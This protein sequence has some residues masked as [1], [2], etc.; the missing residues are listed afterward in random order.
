MKKTWNLPA[1]AA[2]GVAILASASVSP[3]TADEASVRKEFMANHKKAVAQFKA[4][5][6]KG[7]MSMYAPDYKGKSMEGKDETRASVERDMKQAMA[8]TKLVRRADLK[9]DKLNLKGAN[10]D[11]ESTFTL[12]IRAIDSTGQ[13]G[14]KGKTH[15]MVMV[16]RSK[17]K[18][19]KGAEGWKIK[20]SEPLPGST[21]TMDGKPFPPAPS[22]K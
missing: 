8:D 3:V 11:V 5:D 4:R 15:D 9:I 19:V 12:D 2:V 10:A 16:M 1:R 18:W 7:F 13:A 20:W 22:K 17:E 14:P 6:L 21:M